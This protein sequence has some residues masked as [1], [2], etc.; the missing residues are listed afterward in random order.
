[1]DDLKKRRLD[2]ALGEINHMM[3]R[4]PT[5]TEEV[6]SAERRRFRDAVDGHVY[7]GTR[8]VDARI[9]R[10]LPD[11]RRDDGR[12]IAQDARLDAVNHAGR[13]PFHVADAA[14]RAFNKTR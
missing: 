10:G 12:R 2:R 7:P 4:A 13:T 8:H 11:L 9:K 3:G 5:A 6:R 14:Q 1:M